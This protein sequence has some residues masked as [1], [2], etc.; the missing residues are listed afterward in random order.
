MNKIKTESDLKTLVSNRTQE[1]RHL[2][3]KSA[4]YGAD[5]SAKGKKPSNEL[6]KDV[7][8]FANADGGQILIGMAEE[9]GRAS[10][11]IGIGGNTDA[12]KLRMEQMIASNIDPR[13]PGLDISAI[14]LAGSKHV[15]TVDIPP[16]VCKPH[17]VKSSG[18]FYIRQGSGNQRL[19]VSQL[20]DLF[21]GSEAIMARAEAFRHERMG[22]FLVGEYGVKQGENGAIM[23]HV[24]PL[25]H[26]PSKR[27]DLRQIRGD[28]RFAYKYVGP[29]HGTPSP[30]ICRFQRVEYRV[31]M[32]QGQGLPYFRQFVF[33]DGAVEFVVSDIFGR[34]GKHRAL[35]LEWDEYSLIQLHCKEILRNFAELEI[36]PPFCIMVSVLGVSGS[37]LVPDSPYVGFSGHEEGERLRHRCQED[38]LLLHPFNLESLDASDVDGP[39]KQWRDD[40]ANA[41][42][43]PEWP[44]PHRR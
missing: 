33:A 40:I 41:Y 24:L 43:W 39:F 34:R 22:R 12:E 6:A 23:L 2:E 5:E 15:L 3:Y 18:L 1:S 35:L 10:G 38:R 37:V 13:I 19:D 32:R 26:W 20:R 44:K 42:D 29:R 21:V 30:P 7:S 27:L 16:S 28:N 17:Q 25:S 14:P 8:A 9:G 31:E 11:I 36:S 4:P